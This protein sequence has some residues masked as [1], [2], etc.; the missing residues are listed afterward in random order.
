M[1]I[2]VRSSLPMATLHSTVRSVVREADPSLPV[3]GLRP[4]DDVISGS[5]RQ[6]RMLMHLFGGF[7]ALT[8]LL[9]A[10]GTYGMASR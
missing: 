8:L 3:I 9:A 5:L 6:P 4:M 7:A 2:V 1:N 10:V